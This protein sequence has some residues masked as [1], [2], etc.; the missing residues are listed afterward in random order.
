MAGPTAYETLSLV[1]ATIHPGAPR[2][3]VV[4]VAMEIG[5]HS[6]AEYN[7]IIDMVQRALE[8]CGVHRNNWGAAV[9]EG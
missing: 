1:F 7:Q 3:K 9:R 8:S 2:H 4:E 6:A 5:D